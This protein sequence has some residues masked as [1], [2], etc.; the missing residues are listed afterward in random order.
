MVAMQEKPILNLER[1]SKSFGGHRV[2]DEV[3]FDLR[4]GEV[5]ALLGENGAGKSTLIKILSGALKPDGGR[6]F[7]SGEE[8]RPESPL[9]GRR[10]GIAVIYQE[11]TV[12]PHLS[13]EENIMLGQE[14]AKFG[15]VDRKASRE[16]IRRVLEFLCHPEIAPDIPVRNLSVSARQV[17][18]IARA[19]VSQARILVMDEPTSSLSR[20]DTGRLFEIIRKLRQEGVGII[21]V[22]HFL[23]EVLEIADRFTVLRDGRVAGQGLVSGTSVE[24]LIQLMIGRR[25]SEL[26]PRRPRQ[27]GEI[28][29]R[30]QSVM[31][32]RMA[33]PVSLEVRRGEILG[34]AGLV[35]AGRTEFLRAL[36]GLDRLEKG[37]V[38]VSGR[39]FKPFHPSISIQAGLGFLSEDRQ[40]E[41][42]A[43][44]MSLAD[45]LTLSRLPFYR[46]HRLFNSRLQRKV[47]S[48]WIDRF[49][50]KARS[51]EQKVWT[52]SGGNQQKVALARLLHQSAEIFLLDEPTKGIDVMSKAQIY[53]L[54]DRLAA[55]NK[56]VIFV[57]SY[58]PELLGVAD[59]IAVFHRGKLVEVRPVS[60]WTEAA[61]MRAAITGKTGE[62]TVEENRVEPPQA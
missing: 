31:S 34:V 27:P 49:S 24:E 33:Q 1:I 6:M 42:L 52:L 39:E 32:S 58:F 8:Y 20:E 19:L 46:R 11:R 14:M 41:G 5:H 53:E 2:L 59:R 17:V 26:Y 9:D 44:R 57:S 3:N 47:V 43:L 37:T 28:I 29:L 21:Y 25:L 40:T 60:G 51:P 30:S 10:R 35:G 48:E 55:E 4:P 18:E 61:L 45:N 38:V 15:L 50:I 22:S 56:A 36:F 23:E 62:E 7:I 12:A 13:V 16:K 54:I